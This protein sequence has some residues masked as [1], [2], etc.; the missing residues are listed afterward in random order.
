MSAQVLSLGS[1][2]MEDYIKVGFNN[3]AEA[4][5]SKSEAKKDE[6][7]DEDMDMVASIPK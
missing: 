4:S 5:T 3:P 7:R 1:R 2:L 6:D